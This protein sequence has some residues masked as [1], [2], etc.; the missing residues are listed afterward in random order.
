MIDKLNLLL[1]SENQKYL[2]NTKKSFEKHKVSENFMPG[3]NTRTTQWME[4]YP[5]YV[6]NANGLH[7]KDLDGNK[8]LDFM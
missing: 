5:F 2:E 6:D 8:Y 1:E 7:I 3:G 4:P